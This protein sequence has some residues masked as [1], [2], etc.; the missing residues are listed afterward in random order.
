MAS[1]GRSRGHALPVILNP[2][3][4]PVTVVSQID[5]HPCAAGVTRDIVDGFLVHQEKLPAHVGIH[6]QVLIG[7]GMEV[8]LDIARGENVAG[9]TGACAAPGRGDGRD[10]G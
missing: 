9:E 3:R 4:Q 8:E 7:G 10:W 6:P 1:V 2:Q 5:P